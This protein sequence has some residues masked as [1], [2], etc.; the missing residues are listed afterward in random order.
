MK[1]LLMELNKDCLGKTEVENICT[2][3]G[4]DNESMQLYCNKSQ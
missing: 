1:S 4:D 3:K 2:L